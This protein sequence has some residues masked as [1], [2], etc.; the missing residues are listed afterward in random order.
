[1][2][3]LAI[4][5]AVNWILCQ[6]QPPNRTHT[7]GHTSCNQAPTSVTHTHTHTH[8]LGTRTEQETRLKENSSTTAEQSKT[9]FGL[10]KM[11]AE[12]VLDSA[13]AVWYRQTVPLL[14]PHCQWHYSIDQESIH[15][16]VRVHYSPMP[17][18]SSVTY[19]RLK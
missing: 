9:S 19:T 18:Q 6:V 16:G 3:Y 15:R 14:Q 11:M 10:P 4:A 2:L 12:C 1:M 13:G 7:I 17:L 5:F 8:T